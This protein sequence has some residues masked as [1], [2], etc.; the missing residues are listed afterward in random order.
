MSISLKES[1]EI[2]T[3]DNAHFQSNM[4]NS[5]KDNIIDNNSIKNYKSRQFNSPI[6]NNDQKYLSYKNLNKEFSSSIY[7]NK[8]ADENYPYY[9]KYNNST[10]GDDFHKTRKIYSTVNKDSQTNNC[11]EGQKIEK[12][13]IN[14][15]NLYNYE[16]SQTSEHNKFNNDLIG[17]NKSNYNSNYNYNEWYEKFNKFCDKNNKKDLNIIQNE[18]VKN[19]FYNNDNDKENIKQNNII[20]NDKEY[21][22]INEINKINLLFNQINNDNNNNSNGPYFIKNKYSQLFKL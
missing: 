2:N 20:K 21:L 1:Q 10:K 18:N 3:E 7:Q 12:D 5:L 19:H 6:Q 17:D 14:R 22:F 16:I 11:I 15:D 13:Y 4:T 9:F 8:N